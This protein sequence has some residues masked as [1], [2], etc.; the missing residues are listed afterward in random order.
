MKLSDSGVEELGLQ[1]RRS[2]AVRWSA[3]LGRVGIAYQDPPLFG[4]S[5]SYVR[6]IPIV[7]FRIRMF[8]TPGPKL[9]MRPLVPIMLR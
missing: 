6:D 5:I 8:F 1:P 3:L 2:A 7:L 9:I 4:N